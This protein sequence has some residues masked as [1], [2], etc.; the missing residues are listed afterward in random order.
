MSHVGVGTSA[1]IFVLF[2]MQNGRCK[3]NANM[4]GCLLALPILIVTSKTANLH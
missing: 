1:V 3:L 2:M 4:S